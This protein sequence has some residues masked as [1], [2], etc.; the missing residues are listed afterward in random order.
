MNGY[1]L[2]CDEMEVYD[3]A[4][5]VANGQATRKGVASWIRERIVAME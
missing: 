2:R 4:I 5:L 3:I 1:G